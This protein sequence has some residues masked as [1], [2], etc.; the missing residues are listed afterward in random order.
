[1]PNKRAQDRFDENYA[2]LPAAQR[3]N[4]G[5]KSRAKVTNFGKGASGPAGVD[6]GPPSRAQSSQDDAIQIRQRQR[7]EE[8]PEV[9]LKR[10]RP[11]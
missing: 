7:Y 6:S 5:W 4:L 9:N 8:L 3:A 2:K 10:G 1:M 11:R